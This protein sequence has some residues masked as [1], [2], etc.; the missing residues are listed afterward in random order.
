MWCAGFSL[1]WLLLCALGRV[2]FSSCSFWALEHRLTNCGLV[3][4][5]HVGSFQIRDQTCVSFIG[6][7]ILY[8]GATREAHVFH[9]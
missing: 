7:Q 2:G 9:F 3:A 1:W 8:H 5:Q 4:S 6:R